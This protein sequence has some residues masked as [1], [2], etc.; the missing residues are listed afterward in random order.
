ML[1]S[2]YKSVVMMFGNARCGLKEDVVMLTSQV[3]EH[4]E[5]CQCDLLAEVRITEI[6]ISWSD[7][8]LR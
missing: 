6:Y 7:G 1:Y 5:L 3:I 8:L 4:A 2:N